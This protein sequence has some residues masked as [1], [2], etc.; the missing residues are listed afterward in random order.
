[1]PNK[2]SFIH[3]QEIYARQAEICSALSHPVRLMIIDLLQSGTKSCTDI[4]EYIDI[5]KTNLS[6]HLS[7]LKKAKLV[8]FNKKGLFQFYYLL[9]PEIKNACSMVREILVKQNEADRQMQKKL[10]KNLNR[11]AKK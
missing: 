1:M 2:K 9:I 8:D 10:K 5:P 3:D 4:L 11:S 6:Q 7:V